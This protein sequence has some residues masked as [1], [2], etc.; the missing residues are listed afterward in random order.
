[1]IADVAQRLQPGAAVNYTPLAD[2]QISQALGNGTVD[3]VIGGLQQTSANVL[4]WNFSNP[5]F[6]ATSATNL[7]GTVAINL[8]APVGFAL[9]M[10]DSA[11]RDAINGAVEDMR[12]EG[13]YDC[14]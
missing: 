11:L 9:P 12:S 3:V 2:N 5:T 14:D 13:T 7:S 4:A 1:M 8:A 6:D 10:N